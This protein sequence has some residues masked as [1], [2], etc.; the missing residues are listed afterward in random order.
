MVIPTD[1]PTIDPAAFV[2]EVWELILGVV[3]NTVQK[4]MI[5]NSQ[6]SYANIGLNGDKTR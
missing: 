4:M 3:D 2:V 6:I 1:I 5:L